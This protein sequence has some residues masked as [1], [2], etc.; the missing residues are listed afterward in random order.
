M[1]LII[2]GSRTI[3]N[4]NLIKSTIDSL[5]LDIKE[6]ISGT[7]NGIDKLGERYAEENNIDLIKFPADW[8]K[9]GKRA[10][11]L[12]NVEM[13]KYG[14]SCIVFWDGISSGS[15]HMIKIARDYK[16]WLKVFKVKNVY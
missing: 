2:A 3:K 14:N 9:F 13:A 11:Y 10:G 7:A 6:I 12:R 1:K 15:K 4:Y 8:N 16:L 5:N